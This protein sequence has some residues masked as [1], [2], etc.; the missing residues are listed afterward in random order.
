MAWHPECRVGVIGLANG[1]YA[2]PYAAV[3]EATARLAASGAFPRQLRVEAHP[4]I[5]S[6]IR[7]LIDGALIGGDITPII[8]SLASN[9]EQDRAL[10][11]RAAEFTGLAAIHGRLSPED[12]LTVTAPTK[13]S[14]WLRGAAGS[15]LGVR[16]LVALAS[17]MLRLHYPYDAA[18]ACR[19]PSC[20]LQSSRQRSK[21]LRS[22]AS[23]PQAQPSR[24]RRLWP[25]Q[26]S[27][28]LN[29]RL[30]CYPCV[31]SH[32]WPVMGNGRAC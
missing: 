28:P 5:W 3:V 22:G 14:W 11:S 20:S 29:W 2:G 8:P 25:S 26:T 9:V 10:A 32:G 13:V 18:A 6:R 27:T 30:W 21:R 23:S 7:P 16:T 17:T 19:L 24:Q 15:R 4:E 12:G 1:R 31:G